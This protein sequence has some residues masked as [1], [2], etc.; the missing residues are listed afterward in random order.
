M[1]KIANLID[2]PLVVQDV[3]DVD[4][5]DVDSST[6]KNLNHDVRQII[7]DIIMKQLV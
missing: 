1:I 7:T 2:G 3:N 4:V 5:N 6:N